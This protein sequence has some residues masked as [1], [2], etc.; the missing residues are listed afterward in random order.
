MRGLIGGIFIYASVLATSNAGQL[1][2]A[3]KS[4]DVAA[5][6]AAL[7]QGA[8]IEE[9][10]KGA[11][12]LLLAI[13]SSHP[14]AAELLIERG[15]SVTKESG[16]GLPLTAAVLNNSADLMRLLLAHGAD[17]NAAVR[18]ER[19]LHFA[20]AGDCLDCV[21][22]L[23][24][25]G[26]DVNAVWVRGDPT[27]N[28]AIVTA[29]HLAR[30]DNRAEIADYLLAHGV[31]I[32]RP[33]PISAKLAMADAAK[34]ATFFASNCSSCHGKRP[35]DIPTKGPNLWNVV[36]RD[37]ASTKFGGY[38]KTLM[39]WDGAWTYED[40]NIFIAGPTLT[41]PG[42]NMDVRGAPDETDRLNVIAYL[43]TLSDAPAPLP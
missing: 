23:V 9:Q 13:R 18:G 1:H 3:A 25:A 39:A 33:E 32:K 7:D 19:M 40:L 31:I 36:G 4:G 11:T 26:A 10:D 30:H 24:E 2:E 35:Q 17:P 5:I 43:R 42:V 21:K 12:A 38:S 6:A 27:R 8:D 34:G 29:Y 20:V 22:V 15:A 37:K 16:L 28:P 41:T 14:E